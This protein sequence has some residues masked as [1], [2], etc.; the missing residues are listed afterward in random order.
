MVDDK[1]DPEDTRFHSL[2]GYD[3]TKDHLWF[4]ENWQIEFTS[5]ASNVWYK[6]YT[7]MDRNGNLDSITHK[8][9]AMDPLTGESLDGMND[10]TDLKKRYGISS[11]VFSAKL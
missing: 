7:D 5:T 2:V 6:I 9:A 1:F 8:E 10:I 11:V 4:R 3:P